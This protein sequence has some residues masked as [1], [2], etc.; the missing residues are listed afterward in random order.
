MSQHANAAIAL[1]TDAPPKRRIGRALDRITD[2][3][4]L[5]FTPAP[6]IAPTGEPLEPEEGVVL[7]NTFYSHFVYDALARHGRLGERA[8]A[9]ARALRP[10]AGARRDHAVGELRADRQPLPRLLRHRRPTS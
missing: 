7:A 9:D 6:P 4:R 1:W 8:A 2:S 10:D 5:T 3:N